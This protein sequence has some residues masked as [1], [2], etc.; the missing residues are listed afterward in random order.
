MFQRPHPKRISSK[1]SSNQE[2]EHVIQELQ[3]SLTSEIDINCENEKTIV[4]LERELQIRSNKIKS[5]H[6]EIE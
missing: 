4:Q 2:L 6:N 1:S 3:N 5:L